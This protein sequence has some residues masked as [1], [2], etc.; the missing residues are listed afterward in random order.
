MIE[1]VDVLVRG[2][3]FTERYDTQRIRVAPGDY[4]LVE[5]EIGLQIGKIISS[6]RMM[7]ARCVDENLPKIIRKASDSDLEIMAKLEN[8]EIEAR[9][10]CLERIREMKMDMKLIKVVFAFDRSKGL[11]MFTADGRVDFRELV[12]DL[13][14]TFKT[15]IEMKQIGIRDEARLLGG[16]GNCGCTLCCVT[17]LRDFHPVSIKMAK[18]Q[19][20]S[21]IPSKISGLCGRLM[22]CLQY[23]H[24]HYSEQVK[25][26]PKMGK[27]VMTTRG[28]GRVRQLNI[29][30]GLILVELSNGDLEE[31]V[32]ADVT[33]YHIYLEQQEKLAKEQADNPAE[34]VENIDVTETSDQQSPDPKPE[35]VSGR[36]DRRQGH[37]RKRQRRES[38]ETGDPGQKPEK[39]RGDRRRR[40]PR[41]PGKR[42]DKPG[43][44]RQ[45]D[46]SNRMD[47]QEKE[48][49]RS[50]SRRRPP[51]NR[52]ENVHRH[53]DMPPKKQNS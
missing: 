18:D 27:R 50:R 33:P 17:F 47:T 2:E 9:Q 35:R 19:G 15:R 44:E 42:S 34:E 7:K 12:R 10:F 38:S 25:S 4:C 39:D 41:R 48:S 23:E 49:G 45:T 36:P 11:F 13:A 22:C 30:K 24:K 43:E 6:S 46:S 20:L 32:S 51:G 53:N 40:R 37:S 26:M 28:E 21:L 29:L 1:V 52:K 3:K 8:L 16:I 14:H 5:S 31:F